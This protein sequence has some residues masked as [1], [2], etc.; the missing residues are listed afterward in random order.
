MTKNSNSYRRRLVSAMAVLTVF[1]AAHSEG[2]GGSSPGHLTPTSSAGSPQTPS[3]AQTTTDNIPKGLV[4]PVVPPKALAKQSQPYNTT[5]QSASS[6]VIPEAD[7]KKLEALIA[8]ETGSTLKDDLFP[9]SGAQL[10]DLVKKSVEQIESVNKVEAPRARPV[11][12]GMT[13]DFSTRA[14]LAVIRVERGMS[15][16]LS[17]TDALGNAWPIDAVRAGDKEVLTLGPRDEDLPKDVVRNTV[18][19]EVA[20]RNG[21]F[22]STNLS[23]FLRGQKAPLLFWVLPNQAEVDFRVDVTV[24]GSVP[25]ASVP[26]QAISDVKHETVLAKLLT[27]ATPKEAG[28]QTVRV[29]RGS[30]PGTEVFTD[31]SN[32]YVISKDELVTPQPQ[33]RVSNVDGVT[34]FRSP[35]LPVILFAGRGGQAYSMEIAF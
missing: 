5:P 21:S 26:N 11:L 6:R 4:E 20:T 14:G 30:V 23:V 9:L 7:R 15:T 31:G 2:Q 10:R 25:G 22:R 33:A 1:A 35:R 16:A 24:P 34:V 8:D 3:L 13:A 17:F 29:V 19:M 18:T 12:R 27:G 28:L 32:L